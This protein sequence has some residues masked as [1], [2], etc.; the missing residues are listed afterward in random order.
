MSPIQMMYR[1][2]LEKEY[3]IT[4]NVYKSAGSIV[5]EVKRKAD[6]ELFIS[7]TVIK[8]END[9]RFHQEMNILEELDHPNIVSRILVFVF[10]KIQISASMGREREIRIYDFRENGRRFI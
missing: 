6:G 8:S 4:R 5:D 1:L 7:K 9:Q 2:E 3:V 10:L